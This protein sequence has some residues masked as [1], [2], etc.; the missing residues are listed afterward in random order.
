MSDPCWTLLDLKA[1]LAR[2]EAD[3]RGADLAENSIRTYVGRSEV[4]LRWLAGDYRPI[5]PR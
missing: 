1:E 4:F 3:L 5:G 2:F